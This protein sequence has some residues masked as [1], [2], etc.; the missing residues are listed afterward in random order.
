MDWQMENVLL[1]RTRFVQQNLEWRRLPDVLL[2]WPFVVDA[3]HRAGRDVVLSADAARE[4]VASYG[5]AYQVADDPVP[6]APTLGEAIA[7]IPRGAPYVLTVLPPPRDLP[8]DPE[9]TAAAVR[10]LT[11]SHVTTIDP[12]PY[13]VIAGL[14]GEAPAYVRSDARPF[15]EQFDLLGDA[16]TVRMDSWLAIDTFRRQGFGHVLRG[17][18]HVLIVERGTSL[19]WFRPDGSAA[20]PVYAAGI[21]ALRPRFRVASDAPRLARTEP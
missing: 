7:R 15:R 5:G 13:R 10:T 19:V 1:Y 14:A 11:G 21:Y 2:Q 16:M 17:R 6:P 20:E 3:A 9:S 4:V 12:A 18:E 8:V